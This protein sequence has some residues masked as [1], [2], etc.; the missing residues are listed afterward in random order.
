MLVHAIKLELSQSLRYLARSRPPACDRNPGVDRGLGDA[1]VAQR[2][3]ERARKSGAKG[4]DVALAGDQRL[5]QQLPDAIGDAENHA[6]VSL[7]SLDHAC[8]IESHENTWT[9]NGKQ[10]TPSSMGRSV[11][12]ERICDSLARF[13]LLNLRCEHEHSGTLD[14]YVNPSRIVP[15][16]KARLESGTTKRRRDKRHPAGT[17]LRIG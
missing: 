6:V 3:A 2:F 8:A 16:G 4:V 14:R 5:V 13:L 10:R 9:Q 11:A 1:D 7:G 12:G 15:R 17:L